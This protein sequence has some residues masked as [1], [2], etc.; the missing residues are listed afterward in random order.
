MFSSNFIFGIYA[1]FILII[2]C[3]VT[4]FEK[5][6]FFFD[7]YPMFSNSFPKDSIPYI[8]KIKLETQDNE[9]FFWK[10]N[11]SSFGKV[12]GNRVYSV[13]RKYENATNEQKVDKEKIVHLF[14]QSIL[15]TTTPKAIKAIY[16]VKTELNGNNENS[17]I[18]YS[19]IYKIEILNNQEQLCW[20][21]S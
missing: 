16:I 5:K 3:Y 20:T 2:L 10:P 17:N 13:I 11:I 15:S 12:F 21:I 19:N 14:I 18:H 9:Y 4:F 6:I 1:I 8:Y 7:Y